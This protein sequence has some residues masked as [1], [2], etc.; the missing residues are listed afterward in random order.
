MSRNIPKWLAPT[1]LE[2]A[3]A[4][5]AR[6]GDEATVLAGGTFIGILMNQNILTPQIL[7]SLR[8]VSELSFI[9]AEEGDGKAAPLRIGAMTTHRAVER[10]PL[11]RQN[12]SILAYTFS[13]VASPRVRNQATVGGVLADADYASDPPALLEALD[14]RIIAR[15]V[16][17][18]RQIPIEEL[19]TGYYETSLRPDELLVEVRIPQNAG[20][21]VYRK[22]RSRSSEDRPC[23]AVAAAKV[24][25]KLRVVV[26]AVAD[27]PQ[28]FPDI[29]ALADGE[30]LNR[31]LATEIGRRYAESIDPIADSRG[32][33]TYRRRVIA[34]EV[35]RVLEGMQP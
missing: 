24:E 20:R 14:A 26:G 28:Y 6:L 3:L 8:N 19:I 9:E 34:V 30:Q 13:L 25:G 29:C 22:F 23:V 2:E 1:S 10:S 35:R 32:S 11:I 27:R 31:E 4:L 15:S 21:A 17:G 7:L 16:K 33:A 18:E 12:W 5:R